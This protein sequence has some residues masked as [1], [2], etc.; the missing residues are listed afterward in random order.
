MSGGEKKL[1]KASHAERDGQQETPQNGINSIPKLV[2]NPQT[3]RHGIV[4]L[5]IVRHR[6]S[7]DKPNNSYASCNKN[8]KRL[9]GCDTVLAGN[10]QARTT[11]AVMRGKTMPQDKRLDETHIFAVS[12]NK[13]PVNDVFFSST[14]S[15]Q[16]KQVS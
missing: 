5:G 10:T 6:Q 8:K 12:S 7:W 15:R 13:S 3:P 16:R 1:K 11:H 9:Q 14:L 2:M 4:G